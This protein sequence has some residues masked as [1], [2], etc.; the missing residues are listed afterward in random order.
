MGE[1]KLQEGMGVRMHLGHRN[2][3]ST[4]CNQISKCGYEGGILGCFCALMEVKG[5]AD[6]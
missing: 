6:V 5:S 2:I 4:F 1:I 3:I